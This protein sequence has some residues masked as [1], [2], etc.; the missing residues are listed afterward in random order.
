MDPE[1]IPNSVKSARV[2]SRSV[3]AKIWFAPTL[4]RYGRLWVPSYRTWD[5]EAKE[6]TVVDRAESVGDPAIDE[7]H[8]VAL[9]DEMTNGLFFEVIKVAG[10]DVLREM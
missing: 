8:R 4:D 7:R 3:F 10:V 2:L 1:P 9:L 5:G 6:R